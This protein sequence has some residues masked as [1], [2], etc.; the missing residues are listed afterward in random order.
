MDLCWL[1]RR[2]IPH[3]SFEVFIIFNDRE[4]IMHKSKDREGGGAIVRI[5]RKCE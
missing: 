4:L 3:I 5:D 1:Q 2:V